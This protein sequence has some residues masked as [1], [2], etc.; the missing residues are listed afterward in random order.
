MK[1]WAA[2]AVHHFPVSLIKMNV[3]QFSL[4]NYIWHKY[5]TLFCCI[6][7][8]YSQITML[9]LRSWPHEESAFRIFHFGANSETVISCL[10]LK[11]FWKLFKRFLNGETPVFHFSILA[12]WAT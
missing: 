3:I 9:H 8:G 6:I 10:R 2:L 7:I 1:I 12:K 11:N 4:S 5:E